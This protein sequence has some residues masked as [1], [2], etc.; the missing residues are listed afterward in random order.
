MRC[1]F[2]K[3]ESSDSKSVEHIIPESLGNKE[4]ILGN[5]IVCTKCNQYFSLKIEKPVL[6][7][8]YFVSVRHRNLIES[9][10][11]RIPIERAFIGDDPNI[12]IG[13]NDGKHSVFIE[14]SKTIDKIIKGQVNQMFLARIEVPELKDRDPV[15]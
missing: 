9:K 1:I 4:H 8:P 11:N 7:K 14:N 5:G 3:R 12:F 6:E 15:T 10:K 2:C 13:I